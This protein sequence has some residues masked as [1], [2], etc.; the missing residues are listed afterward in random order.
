MT[1]F[2]NPTYQTL[3]YWTLKG[4]RSTWPLMTLIKK[5]IAVENKLCEIAQRAKSSPESS[6]VVDDVFSDLPN[7][8]PPRRRN[9]SVV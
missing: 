9:Q 3:G 6:D 5:S 8:P 2:S 1:I 7:R 4:E